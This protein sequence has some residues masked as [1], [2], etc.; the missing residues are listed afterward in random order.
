M[1]AMDLIDIKQVF[2]RKLKVI[3]VRWTN[4]CFL[5]ITLFLGIRILME[6]NTHGV[7]K[8]KYIRI[9]FSFLV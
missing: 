5:A 2:T 9:M 3:S 1:N 7:K 6:K 8:V 4:T